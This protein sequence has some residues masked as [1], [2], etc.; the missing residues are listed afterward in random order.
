MHSIAKST[1]SPRR[2]VAPRD[3]SFSVV[4]GLSTGNEIGMQSE[5][6]RRTL[7]PPWGETPGE[8]WWTIR[9]IRRDALG[10]PGVA[11]DEEKIMDVPSNPV[12]N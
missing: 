6:P 8:S 5:T 12:T 1:E 2:S 11:V 10:V 9:T 3:I 4:A 7:A